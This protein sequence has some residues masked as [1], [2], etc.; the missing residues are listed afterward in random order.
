MLKLLYT[1]RADASLY[2]PAIIPRFR[3]HVDKLIE[4]LREM[5][6]E[7]Q[8]SLSAAL[9]PNAGLHHRSSHTSGYSALCLAHDLGDWV[10]FKL[11]DTAGHTDTGFRVVSSF[12]D[13]ID[14]IPGFHC[15]AW[16]IISSVL[17]AF[18]SRS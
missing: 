8:K 3:L 14:V 2:A 6:K 10:S 5:N 1:R 7:A 16:A 18:D 11:N 4:Q 13:C 9:L 12:D 17:E 15:E